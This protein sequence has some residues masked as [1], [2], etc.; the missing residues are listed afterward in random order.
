MARSDRPIIPEDNNK[1]P[2]SLA[3]VPPHISTP[4]L[5]HG[6]TLQTVME[7]QKS[8]GALGA[9][10]D[11]LIMDVQDHGNTL[12]D[13]NGKMSFVRGAMRVVGSLV[14]IAIAIGGLLLGAVS[15][16]LRHH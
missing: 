4:M 7:L 14:A 12:K 9:K 13:V 16:L 3:S 10:T 11:R 2:Q 8:V 1:P 5:D 6:F 15:L